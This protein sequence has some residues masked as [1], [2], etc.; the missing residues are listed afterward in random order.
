ML[1]KKTKETLATL[2]THDTGQKQIKQDELWA[3]AHLWYPRSFTPYRGKRFWT[4]QIPTS[5][6][7][8][9]LIFRHIEHK[10]SFFVAFFSAID[11]RNLIFGTVIFW[12]I[13]WPCQ[14]ITQVIYLSDLGTGRVIYLSDLGTGRVICL[15]DLGNILAYYLDK[16]FMAD[17]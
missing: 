3:N 1:Q 5:C 17:S 13:T 10:C 14:N 4:H 7:P 9:L 2:G 12:H 11:G 15:S 8:T 6:L 16:T